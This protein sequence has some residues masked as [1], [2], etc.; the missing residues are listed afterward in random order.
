MTTETNFRLWHTFAGNRSSGGQQ[1]PGVIS[2][3]RTRTVAWAACGD[4][5]RFVPGAFVWG[6]GVL[7]LRTEVRRPAAYSRKTA[8]A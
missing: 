1:V 2:K 6:R 8:A 3:Y 7:A 4:H 5:R